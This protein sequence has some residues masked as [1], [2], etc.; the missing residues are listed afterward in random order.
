[1]PFGESGLAFRPY[2]YTSENWSAL[3]T[4]NSLASTQTQASACPSGSLSRATQGPS[5][6]G[7]RSGQSG[8]SS[9]PEPD[10]QS[11]YLIM[12]SPVPRPLLPMVGYDL[13]WD[14]VEKLPFQPMQRPGLKGK[15]SGNQGTRHS[16]ATGSPWDLG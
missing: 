15:W 5:G 10:G 12:A 1:L 16:L 8:L 6:P 9:V 14:M 4:G 3:T 7:S 2:S 11:A 13:V